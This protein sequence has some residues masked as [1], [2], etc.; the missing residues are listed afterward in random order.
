MHVARFLVILCPDPHLR[1]SPV[2]ILVEGI[3]EILISAGLI[4]LRQQASLPASFDQGEKI[5]V[6]SVQMC[7]RVSARLT[8]VD[9]CA[10]DRRLGD[11]IFGDGRPED[12][13]TRS[14]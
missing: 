14:C 12:E 8:G 2:H 13:G 11:L 9:A 7:G 5:P 1:Q 4:E 3:Q 6:A 10:L